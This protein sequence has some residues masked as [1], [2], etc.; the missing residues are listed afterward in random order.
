MPSYGNIIHGKFVIARLSE[1]S[2]GCSTRRL[3]LASLFGRWVVNG[4][5]YV[6]SVCVG[7]FVPVSAHADSLLVYAYICLGLVIL[8]GR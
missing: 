8:S 3:C 6:V 5:G 7:G 2:Q 4:V 1:K